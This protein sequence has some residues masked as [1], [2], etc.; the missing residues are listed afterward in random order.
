M[1]VGLLCMGRGRS[2]PGETGESKDEGSKP[3]PHQEHPICRDRN[4]NGRNAPVC[5]WEQ[6]IWGWERE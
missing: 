6:V 5:E 3:V 1:P 2:V 4:Y